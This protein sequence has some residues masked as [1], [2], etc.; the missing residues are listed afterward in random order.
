MQPINRKELIQSLR[1]YVDKAVT[2]L[3]HIRKRIQQDEITMVAGYLAYVT[4]LS[5]VPLVAVTFSVFS[6][7]PVFQS[8]QGQI[9]DFVFNNFVPA[10]GDAV[11]QHLTGFAEN[12]K[13]MTAI[14]IG[15]L[16][17]AALLLISAIDKTLNRIW[18]ISGGR[19]TIISFSIYWMVLT[20]GPVLIGSSI[21]VTSY[22]VSLKIF[23]DSAIGGM[24]PTVLRFLPFLLSVCAF[25]I[26]Y[27]LVPNTFV[28]FRNALAGAVLAAVLFE[29]TKK[30]F[31]LYVTHFPSYEAI[32]GALAAIPL[33]F[34]WIYL[35]WS[36]VLLG[37]EL[38]AALGELEA[39]S[40][41]KD[42]EAE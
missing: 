34:I 35:A 37:A 42:D 27:T 23:S 17:A 14:G 7:F 5:L 38:T 3:L 8:V 31:A 25:I 29:L 24:L 12:A 18:R 15:F 33:L 9:E 1:A 40:E 30:G 32:Y 36:V 41:Q 10:S 16:V 21:A 19:R 39:E 20:L 6:A 11:R 4:L 28:R 22:L 2:L 26:L 13:R